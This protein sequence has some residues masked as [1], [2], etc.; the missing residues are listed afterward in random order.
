MFRA[1]EGPILVFKISG[2]IMANNET[3]LL[4][5]LRWTLFSHGDRV[6]VAVSGGPDSLCLL[7][8]LW[9]EREARG[10]GSVEAAHLDH[11]LRGAESAAEADWVAA[12]CRERGISCHVGR[13]D[14][15]AWASQHKRGKQESARMVRYAFLER[16]ASETGADKIATGH[17]RDDQTET[18]LANIMRG[19]GLDGLR[20]IPA[21]RES[22]SRRGQIVRPLLGVTRAEVEAYNAAQGLSPRQDPSNLSAEHYTRNRIRLELLPALRRNYNPRVDDALVRLSEIAA[23]DSDYLARQAAAALAAATRERDRFRLELDRADLAA[24][25]PAL[26]RFT[27]RQAI[28]QVRGSGEGITYEHIEQACR[29]LARPGP[30]ASVLMLP[31]PL[32][33]VRVAEHAFTF[34]LAN[35]PISLGY[36]SLP[37]PMPG[38]AV[39][40]EI[41]WR[42]SAGWEEQ[43][44]AAVLDTDAVQSASL[45]LRN[46]RVGDRVDPLGMGGRHKKVSDIFTDAKVPR[47][48]RQHI[49]IVADASGILWVVGYSIAER[50]KVTASTARRLFLSAERLQPTEMT[51]GNRKE[52][53]E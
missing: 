39:L 11:G 8:V 29:M 38:E 16:T 10:L 48:E 30:A 26:L 25:H 43:S 52:N 21:Q 46:W 7:H 35:V 23:R 15:A 9:A 24:L 37:L 17:T 47:S 13:V 42:V 28:E 32:C 36:L 5:K 45:V 51:A 40:E 49:P 44:G 41:G 18:V 3:A 53:R 22:D 31:S 20:G 34:T 33:T 1:P 6:L 27:L 12:W 4:T 50:A 2:S 14:V 19:T